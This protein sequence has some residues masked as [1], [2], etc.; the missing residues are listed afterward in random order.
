MKLLL[1]F[2]FAVTAEQLITPSADFV[3]AKNSH[4]KE[5]GL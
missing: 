4:T 3:T 5:V 2:V 1:I